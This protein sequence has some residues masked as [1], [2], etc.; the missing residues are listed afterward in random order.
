MSSQFADV[1]RKSSVCRN[2]DKISIKGIMKCFRTA[3]EILRFCQ[4]RKECSHRLPVG[5]FPIEFRCN[6]EVKLAKILATGGF[7]DSELVISWWLHFSARTITWISVAERMYQ[8]K[9]AD[10]GRTTFS[11]YFRENS[12]NFRK[13]IIK[14]S[15]VRNTLIKSFLGQISWLNILHISC[16][17]WRLGLFSSLPKW[18]S[19]PH[20]NY[21]WTL[22]R[23][24]VS[25]FPWIFSN[26][27]EIR[28]R[29]SGTL[30][31]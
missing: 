31:V 1:L 2:F 20:G 5:T 19:Y 18:E 11:W 21:L 16:P 13:F 28:S 23:D 14:A 15:G 7:A 24:G 9:K 22:T 3:Y 30:Q 17:K 12:A 25:S 4:L 26:D 8:V 10:I 29:L 27:I 6:N